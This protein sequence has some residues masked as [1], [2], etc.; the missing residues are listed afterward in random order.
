MSGPDPNQPPQSPN[1]SWQPNYPQPQSPYEVVRGPV[2]PT[3]PTRPTRPAEPATRQPAHRQQRSLLVP[4]LV[5]AVVF[6]V[7]LV[8]VVFI[9]QQLRPVVAPLVDRE[10]PLVKR[11]NQLRSE[12]ISES[13]RLKVAQAITE[14]GSDAV[15]ATL[16]ATASHSAE[17][18]T[19]SFPRPI[20]QTLAAVGH[21]LVPGLKQAI[22]SDKENAR[23]A[24]FQV[25]GEMRPGSVE[26]IEELKAAVNDP[27]G[28]VRSAACKAIGN[29]GADAAPAVQAL[30][31]GLGH[32][33]RFTRR[34]AAETLAKI[35]PA[36]KAAVPALKSA[37]EKEKARDVREALQM[38]LV[39]I[40]LERVAAEAAE[41][42]ADEHRELMNKVA[43][44]KADP[45][46]AVT[47]AEALGAKGASARE[48][49]PALMLAL[50]NPNKQVRVAAIKA[51]A[52]MSPHSRVASLALG[53][54]AADPEEEVRQ[55]AEQA[56]QR[57]EW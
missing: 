33:D 31:G 42:A 24:A 55:A 27:N 38:A 12:T 49:I 13:R 23:I 9:A 15:V 17:S 8:V 3:R 39:E 11:I 6:L 28:F 45:S 54:A 57:I 16:A 35:G 50:R 21:D 53:R 44:L 10:S 30:S 2:G 52:S 36:A 25:L 14:M 1:P 22:R 34:G 43:N 32:D 41:H 5:G 7:A 37:I 51:L 19:F 26:M 18:G 48:T 46:G 56:L 47:A 40:D 20:P 29:L 4:L